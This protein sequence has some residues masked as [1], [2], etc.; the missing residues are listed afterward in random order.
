[1]MT[2]LCV[3]RVT[4][5]V[6]VDKYKNVAYYFRYFIHTLELFILTL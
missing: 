2:L 4:K 3:Y 1:M 5:T 6:S